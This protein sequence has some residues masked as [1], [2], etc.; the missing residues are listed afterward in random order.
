MVLQFTNT[1]TQL[2]VKRGSRIEYHVKFLQSWQFHQYHKWKE[3]HSQIC[4][5]WTHDST[6]WH[7]WYWERLTHTHA[8]TQRPTSVLM[9]VEV[10]ERVLLCCKLV[11]NCSE[12]NQSL[13]APVF[14]ISRGSIDHFPKE[15]RTKVKCLM[16][17]KF[18]Q[19]AAAHYFYY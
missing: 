9:F 10:H 11:F 1:E 16:G 3:L 18:K 2:K 14:P 7:L 17:L 19:F 4:T 5:L 8:W 13:F 12:T 15:K 6:R